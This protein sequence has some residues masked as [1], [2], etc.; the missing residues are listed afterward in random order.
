MITRKITCRLD[1]RH[2]KYLVILGAFIVLMIFM[3][4]FLD[5]LINSDDSSELILANLLAKE[6]KL[7][8]D[9]W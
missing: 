8:T 7:L 1:K 3:Q 2:L 5:N 6:N 9:S 4:L